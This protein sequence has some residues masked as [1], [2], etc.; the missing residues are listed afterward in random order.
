[1]STREEQKAVLRAAVKEML[2]MHG[3]TERAR[4]VYPDGS[5]IIW[6]SCKTTAG[7]RVIF[8][9]DGEFAEAETPAGI[10]HGAP[11]WMKQSAEHEAEAQES[12]AIAK[13][14][15]ESS[16]CRPVR[17]P[18]AMAHPSLRCW[19]WDEKAQA[20]RTEDRERYLVETEKGVVFGVPLW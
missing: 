3:N 14:L 18:K 20:W 9:D 4:V 2:E 8:T 13:V 6:T 19:E 7:C 5:V 10:V 16:K 12:R 15:S 1:M 17:L 11:L